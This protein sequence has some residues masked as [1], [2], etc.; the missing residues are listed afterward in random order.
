MRFIR[1]VWN[2][3][4]SLLRRTQANADL[5]REIELHLEQL[6]RQYIAEGFSEPE[7]RRAAQ[8]EFGP[9]ELTKEHCRDTRR[10]SILENLSKDLVYSL[11]LLKK[12]PGFLL[13][14]VLLLALGI[15]TNTAVFSVAS[16]V[17]LRGL[18]VQNS[19][20]LIQLKFDDLGNHVV[21]TEFSYPA[22]QLF[23]R[24]NP[25]LAGMYARSEEIQVNV[26]FR[27]SS[28]LARAVFETPDA[29]RVLGLTPALGRLLNPGDAQA[30]NERPAMVLSYAYWQKR[31]GGD[32]DVIG[33]D[34]AID[35]MPFVIAGV[36]PAGFHG[37]EVG[38]DPEVTLPAYT[39]DL[40][41]RVP[42]LRN[43]ASWGFAV[44]GRRKPGAT[45]P[46]I[47]ASLEPVFTTALDD[48]VSAV[49]ASMAGTVKKFASKLRLRVDSAAAGASSQARDQLRRPLT[50]LVVI[51]GLVFLV[52]CTNLAG[53]IL[54]K[55][56]SRAPEI[57]IRLAI[58]CTR[59]RLLQ[60]LLTES[61]LMAAAGAAVGVLAA[62][63]ASPLLLRLLGGRQI[64]GRLTIQPDAYTLGYGI[65]LAVAGG[66]LIGLWP[67]VRAVRLDPLFSIRRPA[68]AYGLR[69]S[70][71]TRALIVC[72]VAVSIVLSLT[73]G[74][75][76]RSLQNYR[77]VDAG[78]R[79]DHL[80]TVSVRP[81]LVRY[82]GPRCIAYARQVYEQ[83][84][85]VPGVT[86]VTYSTSPLGQLTWSTL[87]N[88]PGYTPKGTLNDSVGRNIAGPRFVETFGL[89]LLAGRDFDL[90]DTET[91]APVVIVNESF[92]RHFFNT[93]D[94]LGR[95]IS[96]IDSA[97]RKDTIVG[98]VRDARDRGVKEPA[99]PVIYS[100]YSHDPLGWLAFGIRVQGDPRRMQHEILSVLRQA[101]PAVPVAE[102]ETAEALWSAS[103][104][105]E[106]LLAV[107]SALL[108][109]LAIL[110]AMIGL[111]GVLAYRVTRRTREIGIRMALGARPN[112][113]RW[114]AV[115]ESVRLL[116]WGV[117]LG[118]PAYALLSG[119][120]R[121]QVYQV[122]PADPAVIG[123]AV[124]LLAVCAGVATYLPAA[125]AVR[126]N[127]VEALKYE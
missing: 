48:F 110:I 30:T 14:A 10:I 102:M 24:P 8:R 82:D 124:C 118:C 19:E 92:A 52:T 100:S 15:G 98:I 99:K 63:W 72:Q 64:A 29:A 86:S 88:V 103:L 126:V 85:A 32:P 39:A 111:Y 119:L 17:L 18:P 5:E 125:R 1:I 13:T 28:G 91:S 54:A 95:Q 75:F 115:R 87:V 49:P 93:G 89:T 51:T 7:A 108:G 71:F 114:L 96:F 79:P 26:T 77:E 94:V 44:I 55:T 101:D 50:I 53:L 3:I 12:S 45:M 36:T 76:I 9:V 97:A 81:D 107:L 112:Q 58:G 27:G 69:N 4:R 43:S 35:T 70:K 42:T 21:G 11:R 40:V 117:L 80:V 121:A 113:V 56:E 60:Q 23:S 105:R 34:V 123:G 122:A 84:A 41:R 65:A 67:F 74:Q 57:G 16:Q 62:Y 38:V 25:L 20:E 106:R 104:E 68:A 73:A 2:R 47:R 83:L 109:L 127:P 59:G 66:I 116:L 31:F 78:F 33:R 90:R 120:L 61:T 22:F 6:T 46:Q 37:I